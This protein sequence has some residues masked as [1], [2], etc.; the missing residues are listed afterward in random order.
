MTSRDVRRIAGAALVA[1]GLYLVMSPL[2][3]ASLLDRPHDTSSQLINLRASWG[4]PVLGLGAWLAWS[5]GLR[6]WS[7]TVLG[8]LLWSMA[9]IGLARA[10]GFVLDGGPDARQWLWLSLEVAIVVGAALGLRALA[11]RG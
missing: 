1:T 8:L 9:G 6:P 4:G 11:R 10:L 7:R 5:P 2:A 3:V